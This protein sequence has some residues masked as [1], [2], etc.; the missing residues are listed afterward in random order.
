M[1]HLKYG[2]IAKYIYIYENTVKR[3]QSAEKPEINHS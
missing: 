3:V 2:T 1:T